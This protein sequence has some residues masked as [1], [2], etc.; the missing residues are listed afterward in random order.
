MDVA[1]PQRHLHKPRGRGGG[2]R[3]TERKKHFPVCRNSI[4][5]GPLRARRLKNPCDKIINGPLRGEKWGL[6]QKSV[7][8][9]IIS[10]I[11]FWQSIQVIEGHTGNVQRKRRTDGATEGNT[12]LGVGLNEGK[13]VERFGKQEMKH[14]SKSG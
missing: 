1:A 9:G 12:R 7:T 13:V 4:S 11:L 10:D 3:K 6:G 2:D 5:H 8:P 14:R